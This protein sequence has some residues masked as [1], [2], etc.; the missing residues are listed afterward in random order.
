MALRYSP[1]ATGSWGDP[2]SPRG[3]N[4]DCAPAGNGTGAE[5]HPGDR[6]RAAGSSAGAWALLGADGLGHEVVNGL[7]EGEI[8]Y[9]HKHE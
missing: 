1:V 5:Q 9:L 2:E 6:R 3:L 8:H 4:L 7:F